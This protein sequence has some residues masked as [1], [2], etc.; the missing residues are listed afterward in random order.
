VSVTAAAVILAALVLLLVK[1]KAVRPVGA[2]VCVLLGLVVAAGPAGPAVQQ[3]LDD[4]GTWGY[5]KL[6]EL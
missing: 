2:L 4:I 6:T 3:A 5:Q 1:L